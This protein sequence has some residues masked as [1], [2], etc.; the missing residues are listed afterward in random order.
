MVNW[1]NRV[2]QGE[3][4]KLHHY[5]PDRLLVTGVGYMF[6][7]LLCILVP[8]EEGSFRYE[9]NLFCSIFISIYGALVAFIGVYREVKEMQSFCDDTSYEDDDIY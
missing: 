3:I 8:F 4:Y 9:A 7:G 5:D 2:I 6:L 1:I